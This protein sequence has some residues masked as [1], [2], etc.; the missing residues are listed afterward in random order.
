[1][2]KP[3]FNLKEWCR[4]DRPILFNL[5]QHENSPS[6]T[7]MPNGDVVFS[8]DGRMIHNWVSLQGM[9][10]DTDPGMSILD[11]GRYFS[12]T[13]YRAESM[14]PGRAPKGEW[15]V[16]TEGEG[17]TNERTQVFGDL[18]QWYQEYPEAN[19][20]LACSEKCG[21]IKDCGSFT[22][23]ATKKCRV[24]TCAARGQKWDLSGGAGH[25]GQTVY[26]ATDGTV[27]TTFCGS[28]NSNTNFYIG[29]MFDDSYVDHNNV[30]TRPWPTRALNCQTNSYHSCYWLA[31]CGNGDITITFPEERDVAQIEIHPY[32]RP[33]AQNNFIMYYKNS[34][35][36]WIDVSG[37]EI[38]TKSY[39]IGD[40][41]ST[42]DV[43]TSSSHFPIRAKEWKIWTRRGNTYN[44]IDEI[45]F[46]RSSN[47]GGCE[48]QKDAN[49]MLQSPLIG[50]PVLPPKCVFPF[51]YQGTSYEGCT[52]I[53]NQQGNSAF[54]C[55]HT[56]VYANGALG[57]TWSRCVYDTYDESGNDVKGDIHTYLDAE[58]R[59]DASGLRIKKL[60]NNVKCKSK[61]IDL[62]ATTTGVR[63]NVESLSACTRLCAN[64]GRCNYFTYGMV[65]QTCIAEITADASCSEGFESAANTGFYEFVFGDTS[66][67]WRPPSYKVHGNKICVVTG[68]VYSVDEDTKW[69]EETILTLPPLCRPS[70]RLV[71][72]VRAGNIATPSRVDVL[73]SG[74]VVWMKGESPWYS[75]GW[76]QLDGISFGTFA[77]GNIVKVP[78]SG[79]N[80]NYMKVKEQD[81]N[82]RGLKTKIDDG[83]A[84]LTMTGP[85][86]RESGIDTSKATQSFQN[87][88]AAVLLISEDVVPNNIAGLDTMELRDGIELPTT[89]TLDVFV[90]LPLAQANDRTGY[91]ALFAG[92]GAPGEDM[93]NYHAV[94]KMKATSSEIGVYTSGFGASSDPA[95]N[96]CV[97]ETF[98]PSGLDMQDKSIFAQRDGIFLNQWYRLTIVGTNGEERFYVD[99]T[100]RGVSKCQLTSELSYVG[101]FIPQ[102]FN[103][104]LITGCH[105]AVGRLCASKSIQRGTPS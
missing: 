42:D 58:T 86:D 67:Q 30:G 57:D 98:Y 82:Y 74:R 77:A 61:D 81:S 78:Q 80:T 19:D 62:S 92:V 20:A 14:Y 88:K 1:M 3:Q 96:P 85:D 45:A 32:G 36:A 65:D 10:F 35:G 56:A 23:G 39:G 91:R 13:T 24:S 105:A 69:D 33:D 84:P 73:P 18:A 16:T 17:S 12:S 59:G 25:T 68:R 49:G 75:G 50:Q 27:V 93:G 2:N 43:S 99:G 79:W 7:V 90:K 55:S 66:R 31:Q 94:V 26:T 104:K 53:D 34:V 38:D 95:G 29:A 47:I 9:T 64:H 103:S 60:R 51:K 52:V 54:G 22:Y 71:F 15:E 8:G 11:Y 6:F 102:D 87:G 97:P 4:P 46:F 5:N 63:A 70:M 28:Y 100:L 41:W 76:V 40:K 44:V 21:A 72:T 83:A 37:G 89:W 101:N 48:E